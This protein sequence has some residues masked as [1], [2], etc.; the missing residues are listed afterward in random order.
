MP[1]QNL[2]K[3][4]V[5]GL[6]SFFKWVNEIDTNDWPPQD[7]DNMP[8]SSIRKLIAMVGM[9]PG[10]ALFKEKR[11]LGCHR[12]GEVGSDVGPEMEGVGS[13]YDKET[14]AKYIIDPQKVDPESEMPKQPEIRPLEATRI[15]EFLMGLK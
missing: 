1:Q 12:I 2:S 15:A 11:C 3:E 4:E 5:Q 9:S 10:A 7:S 13:K 6:V 8:Q 14:L